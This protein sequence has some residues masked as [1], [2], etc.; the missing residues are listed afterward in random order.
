MHIVFT[1]DRADK[2]RYW[3][4]RNVL[5]N[6]PRPEIPTSQFDQE[7][8]TLSLVQIFFFIVNQ[9]RREQLIKDLLM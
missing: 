6:T 1:V 8:I 3:N 4:W 5:K 7:I 2:G 9:L